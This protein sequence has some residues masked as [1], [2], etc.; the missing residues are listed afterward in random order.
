[1]AFAGVKSLA[2]SMSRSKRTPNVVPIANT[3][4]TELGTAITDLTT[5]IRNRN[6][7]LD[8]VATY[9]AQDA[10]TGVMSRASFG[11]DSVRSAH[12]N[13]AGWLPAHVVADPE[14]ALDA[15]ARVWLT[16][17][18]ANGN[19]AEQLEI[20]QHF[21]LPGRA[22]ATSRAVEESGLSQALRNQYFTGPFANHL[23]TRA[24]RVTLAWGRYALDYLAGCPYIE[25]TADNAGGVSRFI[26]NYDDGAIYANTHYNWV[27][28]FNPFFEVTGAPAT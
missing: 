9:A 17:V 2:T 20:N 25:F 24:R 26:W 4:G 18:A 22:A 1:V 12:T 16:Q 19:A 7:A 15:I 6:N 3:V 23:N 21:P 28:G 11:V 27:D 13:N 10:N 8:Q 5:T 14:P